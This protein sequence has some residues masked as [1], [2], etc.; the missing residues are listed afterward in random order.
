MNIRIRIEFFLRFM[1]EVKYI[2]V[3]L[4]GDENLELE[5]DSR[6]CFTLSCLDSLVEV[7]TVGLRYMSQN[8]RYRG[9]RVENAIK[10][11]LSY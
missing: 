11:T 5:A 9:V 2:V 8:S 1:T 10:R 3:T 4:N 7:T 6:G